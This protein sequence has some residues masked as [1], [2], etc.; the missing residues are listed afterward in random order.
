MHM[1][2]SLENGFCFIINSNPPFYP[3]SLEIYSVVFEGADSIRG[4]KISK[5]DFSSTGCIFSKY[6]ADLGVVLDVIHPDGDVSIICR[7]VARHDSLEL[8]V[9]VNENGLLDYVIINKTWIP[10]PLG[11]KEDVSAFFDDYNMES[12]GLISL[13]TY[14]KIIRSSRHSLPVEDRTGS[15]LSSG[16]L[17]SSLTGTPPQ[18]LKGN[19]YPYQLNGYRWLEFITRDGLGCIIADEMGLGKTLQVISLLLSS[20]ERGKRPN[21]VIAPATILENWRREISRF[22]PSLGTLVHSGSRRTG[23]QSIL[24]DFDVV[25][26]SYDTAVA[27]ISLFKNINWHFI[28]VDEAQNIK[29]PSAKRT[30]QIKTLPR[31]SAVAVTGTPV[32]NH[33]VDLWSICDFVLPTLL[34]SVQ[35]FES[36]YSDDIDGATSLEPVVSP[37]IL[38]RRVAEVANDLPPR[39]EIPQPLELDVFSAS[40]YERIRLDVEREYSSGSGIAVLTKLRMFC[41]HPWIVDSCNDVVDASFCSMK[42]Q[43]LYEILDEIISAGEKAIIFT[44][45]K[46]SIDLIM[47]VV[48]SKYKIPVYYIDGR[49][50]VI[51]RQ[52]LVDAFSSVKSSSVL[53]LNPK[54]AGT[55]LNITSANHVIHYNLEWNPAVEDQASARSH[56]RG[57]TR[58]VTI[59]RL[60]YVNTVE[61]VI[62]DRMMLKRDMATAAIV[63]TTG[64]DH[65]VD[66]ILRAIRISPVINK[67]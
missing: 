39:I 35:E 10:L 59:H 48:D 67:E 53:V 5:D 55:G 65:D 44:S 19:L 57:Q 52:S 11:M 15:S 29:N 60:F 46:A 66:D 1:S 64:L 45:Y 27:D 62:N 58:P 42:M 2:V 20:T 33:L 26:S 28:I 30:M 7:L 40:E 32:E 8:D 37:V 22:A 16:T 49:V 12:F 61:E 17:S 36:R 56:R 43:R 31:Y 13:L 18:T 9:P 3:S 47:S 51:D 25:I 23:F 24:N 21:L 4:I 34:G 63:G 41:T 50:P 14:L 54:A 38:R 6:I